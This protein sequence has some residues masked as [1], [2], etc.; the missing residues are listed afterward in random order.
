MKSKKLIL[1]MA[2]FGGVLF[3]VAATNIFDI[4]EQSIAKI[5]KTKLKIR[6]WG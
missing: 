1:A 4:N 3:T 6:K 2:I 5:D